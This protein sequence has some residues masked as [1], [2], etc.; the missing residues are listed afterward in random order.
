MTGPVERPADRVRPHRVVVL[1]KAPIRGFVKTR[2]AS[3]VGEDAALAVHR[4]LTSHV[5]AELEMAVDLGAVRG[6][7]EA[8]IRVTPDDAA[9][10]ARTWVPASIRITPQGTG[11]LGD[12][13]RRAFDEAFAEGASFV[14]VVGT[15]CPGFTRRH[16]A[17]AFAA[18]GQADVVIGPATDGGF[19]LLGARAP[20][21]EL[22]RDVP[23]STHAVLETTQRLARASG[24][25]VAL[26]ETLS[27]IDTIEDLDRLRRDPRGHEPRL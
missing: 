27:D 10:L 11:D 24:R 21:P 12:R 25:T 3:V 23:W 14:V 4:R 2:L 19:W 9:P 18:L 20:T 1:A 17:D 6:G 13:M 22:F 15:D 26:L 16:P 5:L 8:E 7:L